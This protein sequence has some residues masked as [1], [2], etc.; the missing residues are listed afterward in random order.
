MRQ[1]KDD[2]HCLNKGDPNEFW[3]FELIESMTFNDDED[4]M[5]KP[6]KSYATENTKF[7]QLDYLV[8]YSLFV[9]LQFKLAKKLLGQGRI[10]K[11]RDLISCCTW[12]K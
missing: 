7:N 2:P 10:Q 12:E 3:N 6:S 8:N 9:F 11:A 1:G 5:V 4:D